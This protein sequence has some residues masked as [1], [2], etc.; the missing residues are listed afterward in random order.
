MP[1][2]IAF[3]RAINVGGHVVKMEQLRR[4]FEA[5]ALKSVETFIA[6]GNVIFESPS[7]DPRVLE[8]RIEA[9]LLKALG[10]EVKTFLRTPAEVADVAEHQPFDPAGESSLYVAFLQSEPARAA[11]KQLLALCTA[12][13]DFHVRNR[14]VYWLIRHKRMT[15]SLFSGARLEKILGT[16][17]TMRNTTTVKRLAARYPK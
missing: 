16:P 11:E 6:S 3:L 8:A 17:M 4:L 5:L 13:D 15:E 12:M 2:Y 14:E 10:Y 9:H 1:R 7:R